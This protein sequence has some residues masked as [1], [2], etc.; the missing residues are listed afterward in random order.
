MQAGRQKST[1]RI[2]YAHSE[3]AIPLL[4]WNQLNYAGNAFG[5]PYSFRGRDKLTFGKDASG[6]N[7]VILHHPSISKPHAA[8]QF[9][10]TKGEVAPWLMDLESVNQTFL[11]SPEKVRARVPVLSAVA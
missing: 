9:R 6:V 3:F 7:A 4:Q 5:E 11:W 2:A 1:I 8:I 10:R